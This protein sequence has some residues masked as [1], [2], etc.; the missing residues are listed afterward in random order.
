MLKILWHVCICLTHWFLNDVLGFLYYLFGICDYVQLMFLNSQ[1]WNFWKT[2]WKYWL[3]HIICQKYSFEKVTIINFYNF[4]YGTVTDLETTLKTWL[5]RSCNH[6]SLFVFQIMHLRVRRQSLVDYNAWNNFPGANTIFVLSVVD[7]VAG[8]L[9]ET[10]SL[11]NLD[12]CDLG[13]Q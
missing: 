12:C 2:I 7:G 9:I 8:I 11:W 4:K 10:G 3:E 5:V 13:C 1:Q 6:N